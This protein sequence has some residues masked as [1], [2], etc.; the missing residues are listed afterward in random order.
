MQ[1]DSVGNIKKF[2]HSSLFLFLACLLVPLLSSCS[3]RKTIVNSLE[4]KDALEIVVFLTSKGIDVIMEPAVESSGGGGGSKEK[5]FDIKVNAMDSHEAMSLLNQAGLPRRP[6]S[7]LLKIFES[8]GLV[9]SEL[10]EQIRYQTGLAQQIASTIRKIDGVLDAE[11]QLSFPK[12][13]PLNPNKEKQKITASVYVKYSGL[14]DN[15]NVHL[16]SMI[17]KL[18]SSSITGLSYDNV[19]VIL[20]RAR[21]GE[22][23]SGFTSGSS[24][25]EKE[26]VSIWSV[27]VAKESVGR[28]RTIF[29]SFSLLLLMLLLTLIWLVWKI[30]P[31]LKQT[32]VKEL[33]HIH[34]IEA[35]VNASAVKPEEE[36]K[37]STEPEPPKESK[38]QVD[39]DI[40]E[41]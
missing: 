40:D 16:T 34:P 24:E 7:N 23:P 39:S 15:P 21:L 27:I 9:P 35:T 26:Y 13:D 2:F 29:F 37:E 38:G 22:Q 32:G 18:V 31:I 1:S 8:S 11:V 4:E 17:K 20:D 30:L 10:S 3:D 5:R 33:L 14:L 6:S 19:T 12:E 28:F 25:A 36:A 41:T